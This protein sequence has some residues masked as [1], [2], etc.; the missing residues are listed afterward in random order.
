MVKWL[1]VMSIL[2]RI[3][4]AFVSVLVFVVISFVVIWAYFYH[5]FDN[6]DNAPK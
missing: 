2:N 1:A 3:W 6:P 5:L 4:F